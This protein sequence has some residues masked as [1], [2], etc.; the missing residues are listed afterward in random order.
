MKATIKLP[1]V[2]TIGVLTIISGT[3]YLLI[4]ICN[5]ILEAFGAWIY[6]QWIPD[7]IL[8]GD[9]LLFLL[10]FFIIVTGVFA[11]NKIGW[12]VVLIGSI[13]SIPVILGIPALVLVIKQ[14]QFMKYMLLFRH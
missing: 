7:E 3:V 12:V 4:A 5:L 11:L 2:K 1:Y 14:R 6:D 8:R 9:I 10:G 13:C